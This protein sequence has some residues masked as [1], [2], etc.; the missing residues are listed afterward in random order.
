ML[1]TTEKG[2]TLIEVLVA[3]A[4][5]GGIMAVASEAVVVLTRTSAQT[6][7]W[8][9][10]LRQVQN[11]GH[12][13]S[14]DALMAQV[15]H[16]DT[17]GDLLDLSWSDWDGNNFNVEYILDGNTLTRQLDDG[18]I[19]SELFIA[20]F[21]DP[22]HTTCVWNDQDN[23]LIVTIRASLN[24]DGGRFVERIYEISPRATGGG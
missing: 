9:I 20:Q 24:G 4:I 6:N 21:I 7:E 23:R 10:N 5:L 22:I 17:P 15:V 16:T 3:L 19:V 13:I 8:N 2:F 11:A 12:W 1:K 14:R 18:S